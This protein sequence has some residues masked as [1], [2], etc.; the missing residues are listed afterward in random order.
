MSNKSEHEL[1]T[2]GH[3]R[4][5]IAEKRVAWTVDARLRDADTLPKYKRGGQVPPGQPGNA[6]ATVNVAE[7]VHEQPPTNPFL[8]VRCVEL[9]LLSREEQGTTGSSPTT[10][11]SNSGDAR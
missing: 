3:L 9:N 2:A 7:L 4:R 1:Q 5:T 6:T 11:I 10:P 8:R